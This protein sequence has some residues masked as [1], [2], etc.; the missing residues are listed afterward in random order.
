MKNA[1]RFINWIEKILGITGERTGLGANYQRRLKENGSQP[2]KNLRL[3]PLGGTQN[4]FPLSSNK[5]IGP[6]LAEIV[7]FRLGGLRK[8]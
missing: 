1:L 5:K 3:D 2:I 6:N 7:K 8:T 4:F